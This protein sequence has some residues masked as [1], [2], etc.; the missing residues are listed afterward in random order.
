MERPVVV[1]TEFRGV[2]FGYAEDTSGDTVKLKRA[3][4]AIYWPAEQKGFMGLASD[5]PHKNARIGPAADIDLRKVT[6][7]LECTEAAVKAWEAEPWKK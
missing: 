1:T 6:A 7:V 3:R 2:F 5:G 4:C